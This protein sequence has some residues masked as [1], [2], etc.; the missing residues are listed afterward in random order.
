MEEMTMRSGLQKTTLIWAAV[1]FFAGLIIG[2]V[3][4][5]WWIWPVH[6]INAAPRHLRADYKQDYLIMAVEAYAYTH[7]A[8]AAQWRFQGLG[9][10]GEALLAALEQHPPKGV[11]AKDIKAFEAALK[12]APSPAATPATGNIAPSPSTTSAAGKATPSPA[13]PPSTR[14]KKS[15]LA[16]VLLICGIGVLILVAAALGFFFLNKHKAKAPV[17]AAQRA[18]AI[19]ASIKPTDYAAEGM[20]EPLTQFMTTYVHGD[21]LYDDSF[22]IDAPNG[23]FLGECGVGIGDTVGTGEPKNV[24]A[25][26]VWIFDKNDIQTITKVLMTENAFNDPATRQRLSAKGDPVMAEPNGEV[27]LETDHLRMVARVIDMAYGQ[28]ATSG[29]QYFERMTLELAIWQKENTG[30]Q[31]VA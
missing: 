12:K 6:W 28:D 29:T 23:E 18:E 5:G 17:T 1:S 2:L 7:D 3:V 20:G 9:E 25:F 13:A 19:R 24:T 22:S 8:A 15:G 21:D 16:I 30:E 27:V 10:D 11:N 31:T 26:E 14:K 4:L